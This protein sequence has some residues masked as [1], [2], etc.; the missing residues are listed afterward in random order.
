MDEVVAELREI[1]KT[2]QAIASSLEQR[3][4]K[5]SELEE[6]QLCILQQINEEST[7]SLGLAKDIVNVMNA[8]VV[9]EDA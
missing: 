7:Y 6:N 3:S 1:K 2:L 9:E 5:L 4:E 8:I